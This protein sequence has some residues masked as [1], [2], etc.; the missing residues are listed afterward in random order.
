MV[1]PPYRALFPSAFGVNCLIH[2]FFQQENILSIIKILYLYDS[3]TMIRV[4]MR[5]IKHR[6]AIAQRKSVRL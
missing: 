3:I 4:E 1:Q 5:R 6:A 2:N